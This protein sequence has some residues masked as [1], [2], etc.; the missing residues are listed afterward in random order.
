MSNFTN[1]QEVELA[2]LQ[3]RKEL[4]AAKYDE[5]LENGITHGLHYP[6][7]HKVAFKAKQELSKQLNDTESSRILSEN[8]Q[9]KQ[10]TSQPEFQPFSC[11]SSSLNDKLG[12]LGKDV[13]L[14]LELPSSSSS[15][16]SSSLLLSSPQVH[17]PPP[18]EYRPFDS[19][20]EYQTRR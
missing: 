8:E 1:T 2:L 11:F 10:S 17:I 14:P 13:S 18:R 16:S 6:E 19:Y 12:I 15:S 7:A 20:S 3:K 9:W 4:C 5:I